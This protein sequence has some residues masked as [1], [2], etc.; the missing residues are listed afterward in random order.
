[1]AA[2]ITPRA[3]AYV[4]HMDICEQYG[5]CRS[6]LNAA[7]AARRLELY[8]RNEQVRRKPRPFALRVLMQLKDAMLIVLMAAAIVSLVMAAFDFS[9]VALLEPLLIFFI[10]FANALISSFQE[11]KAEKSLAALEGM[12]AAKCKVRRDGK[13]FVTDALPCSCRATS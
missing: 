3:R 7:E 9:W 13:D 5:T 10:V 2:G 12:T 1:M 4:C 11:R 6:G 8:G